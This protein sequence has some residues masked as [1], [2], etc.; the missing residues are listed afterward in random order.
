MS[1]ETKSRMSIGAVTS[2]IVAAPIK[3]LVYGPEGVGKTSFAAG[4]PSPIFIPIEEGTN[5]LPVARFPA[6]ETFQDVLDAITELGRT[7]H[8]YRTLV[9]DTLDALEPLIWEHVVR[10]AGK[11]DKI[12][13][14]EDFGYGKGYIAALDSWR[15]LLAYLEK[16]RRAK[17]INVV[18]LAHSQIKKFQNPEGEDFDRFELKLA[19]KGASGVVKEWSDNVLFATYEVIA[20]TDKDTDRTRGFS[21]GK[22]VARTTHSGAFDA[23]NRYSLPDP[24]ELS[25]AAYRDGMKAYLTANQQSQQSQQSNQQQKKEEK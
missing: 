5:H 4:A 12:K 19:G 3:T 15:L 20:S 2:G 10:Q 18:M 9:L 25:W 14:I 13:S 23:K 22:R 24:L 21:T 1:T 11:P 7:E 6:P 17:Q 16:L 8:P